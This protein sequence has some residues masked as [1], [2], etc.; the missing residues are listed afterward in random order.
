M[1][2]F[3]EFL[4]DFRHPSRGSSRCKH[5]WLENLE[6][7]GKLKVLSRAGAEGTMGFWDI[8]NESEVSRGQLMKDHIK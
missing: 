1:S 7:A 6:C 3:F 5:G 2:L 8:K 4:C